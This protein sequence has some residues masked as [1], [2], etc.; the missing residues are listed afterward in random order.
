MDKQTAIEILEYHQE[1]MLLDSEV[2]YR[3]KLLYD[4]GCKLSDMTGFVFYND[5]SVTSLPEICQLNTAD[6]DITFERIAEKISILKLS[7]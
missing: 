6:W 3:L 7:V 5:I 4:L 1:W 2:N